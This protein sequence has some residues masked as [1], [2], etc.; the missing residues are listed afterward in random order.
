MNDRTLM[1]RFGLHFLGLLGAALVLWQLIGWW[2]K[3]PAVEFDNLKYIQLL[4]TAVS[5]RKAD[6]VS[7]V[8][9]AIRQRHSQSQM[10]DDELAHFEEILATVRAGKWEDADRQ[11]F[12]FAAAQLSRKRSPIDP[13]SGHDHSH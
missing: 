2:T 6:M 12:D 5:S 7:K 8:E 3:P 11:T 9:K 13:H 10:S 4:S 1:D